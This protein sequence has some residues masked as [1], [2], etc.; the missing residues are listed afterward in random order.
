M[1]A[2]LLCLAVGCGEKQTPK[3]LRSFSADGNSGCLYTAAVSDTVRLTFISDTH[4]HFS[5]ER[6][7]PFHNYSNRMAGAYNSTRHFTSGEQ[8]DPRT[9]FRETL[10]RARRN[11]TDL[12][13]LGGDIFSFPSEASV[14][15]AVAELAASGLEYGYTTGN[16]DWHYEGME[17][18]SDELRREWI[19]RRLMGLYPE[20]ADPMCYSVDVKDARVLFFDNSTYEINARQLDFFRRQA[21]S[22]LPL[23]VV[24]HIPA[25]FPGR[26]VNYGCGHP[27]WNAVADGLWKTERRRKWP[28]EGHTE[29]TFAFRRELFAA[30]NVLA[31]VAGHVHEQT[32]DCENGTPQ[33]T[34]A[35]NAG[36]AFLDITIIPYSQK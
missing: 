12:V 33:F 26:P 27:D 2:M 11:R 18:S 35:P 28:A 36:G 34:A 3:V 32:L 16:H 4:L 1:A 29:T 30:S 10:A 21:A 23:V 9:A 7:E 15:W 8:T 5:D 25:W 6:E 19:G 20:G 31:V 24:M 17:G 14:E 22:G 13:A